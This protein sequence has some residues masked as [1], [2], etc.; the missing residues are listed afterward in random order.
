MEV[1]RS[2]RE[3]ETNPPTFLTGQISITGWLHT[4]YIARRK[5]DVS[6]RLN[7]PAWPLTRVNRCSEMM[8]VVV[9]VVVVVV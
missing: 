5:W 2:E 9:G 4:D 7:Y 6:G 1:F 8:M 3:R